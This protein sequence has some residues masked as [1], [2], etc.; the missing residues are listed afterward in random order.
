MKKVLLLICIMTLV[1]SCS[2]DDDNGYNNK[3]TFEKADIIGDWL[4]SGFQNIADGYPVPPISGDNPWLL[5][6]DH[7]GN[8]TIRDEVYNKDVLT[9][10]WVFDGKNIITCEVK[11]ENKLLEQDVKTIQYRLVDLSEN[12]IV[13]QPVY[14]DDTSERFYTKYIKDPNAPDNIL[15]IADE[16]FYYSYGHDG[17][18]VNIWKKEDK[19][20][21]SDA[22]TLLDTVPSNRTIRA[23]IIYLYNDGDNIKV[24]W[25]TN[26]ELIAIEDGTKWWDSDR[27]KWHNSSYATIKV[28]VDQN[29]TYG[30]DVVFPTRTVKR[31]K[32]IPQI[33]TIKDE[34]D[35]FGF[36][37]GANKADMQLT[38]EFGPT[39]ALAAN[40]YADYS[41]LVE[42][43]NGKLIRIYCR[44]T[45][46]YRNRLP[47]MAQRLQIPEPLLLGDYGREIANPQEWDNGLL[48][49]K[50]FNADLS[51]YPGNPFPCIS[52]EKLQK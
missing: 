26:G 38:N 44:T 17:L 19:I 23:E 37:F 24:N 16:T 43:E 41:Y 25:S 11:Y 1:I 20:E 12:E 13:V 28:T 8:I 22:Y 48:K 15:G 2:K 52:I 21:F 36:N 34:S 29:F 47:G 6:F 14:T 7:N 9:G 31:F 4:F 10:T 39:L 27:Q 40:Q 33:I 5:I 51:N 45:D 32:T 46:I 30:A 42:F 49:F 50:A 18:N 3:K 35:I